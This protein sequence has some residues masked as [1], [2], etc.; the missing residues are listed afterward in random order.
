L[1]DCDYRRGKTKVFCRSILLAAIIAFW[2]TEVWASQCAGFDRDQGVLGYEFRQN[3]DRCEG[4]FQALAAGDIELM[5][6]SV[7]PPLNGSRDSALNIYAPDI[8]RLGSAQVN[9]VVRTLSPHV[10][11]RMDA[12]IGS[13]GS[14]Q[15]PLSAVVIPGHLDLDDLGLLGLVS[16]DGDTIFVPLTVS[17]ASTS[18]T[19]RMLFRS[20]IDV[21]M[22][23]WRLFKPGSGPSAWRP[24]ASDRIFYAGDP[25]PVTLD[26]TERGELT[27]ELA[28]RQLH[29]SFVPTH[30]L[31][32]FLP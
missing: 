22:F 31:E 6:F 21:D 12:T 2:S 23:K 7:G 30:P 14:F 32:I 11:Y 20:S 9:V 5:S 10:F 1:T 18:H 4:F 17:R 26:L 28:V 16:H 15:W 13:A 24:V 25:I 27:L 29:G 19:F 3:P 8:S